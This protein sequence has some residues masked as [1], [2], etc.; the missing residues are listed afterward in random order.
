MRYTSGDV[1]GLL[2]DLVWHCVEQRPITFLW[3]DPA[4]KQYTE[5][6]RGFPTSVQCARKMLQIGRIIYV[7]PQPGMPLPDLRKHMPSKVHKSPRDRG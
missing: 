5:L 3:I 2:I 7:N 1:S 4:A 6:V